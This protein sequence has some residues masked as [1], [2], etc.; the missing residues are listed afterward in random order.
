MQIYENLMGEGKDFI[1]IETLSFEDKI[2]EVRYKW[3]SYF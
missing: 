2:P 1:L 3:D